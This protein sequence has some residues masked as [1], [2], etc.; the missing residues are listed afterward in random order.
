MY[1]EVVRPFAVA[2]LA[3]LVSCTASR[4]LAQLGREGADV[5]VSIPAVCE[6][7]DKAKEEKSEEAILENTSGNDREP[8]IMNAV[9]DPETGEM[10]ASDVIDASKVVARFRNV[11][12]RNGRVTIEFDVTVPSS[13]VSSK[14]Q[15]R[16]FPAAGVLDETF[17][18]DPILVTGS[19]YRSRQIRGYERYREFISSIISDSSGFVMQK[20]LE[21]FLERNYPRVYAMKNDTSFVSDPEAE[22]IFGVTQKEVLDHYTRHGLVKR[23]RRREEKSGIMLEK[24]TGGLKGRIRLDT[25]ISSGTEVCYRYVQTLDSRPGLRKI[26]VWLSGGVYE[27]GELVY[28]IPGRNAIDFYV[29]SLSSL[30]DSAVRY[31]SV[32]VERSVYGYVNAM[33]DFGK[34]SALLD[35]L[36]GSN[37]TELA[38]MRAGMESMLGNSDYE[39]DSVVVTASCSLEGSYAY[40]SSLAE[41][42]AA[43]VVKILSEGSGGECTKILRQACRPENWERF[44]AVI[45]DDPSVSEESRTLIRSLPYKERPDS[46]EKVLQGLPE[47]RYLKEKVY[48]G[49]R[50][51]RLDFYMHR[52]GMVKDTLCTSEIDS[53]YMRGVAALRNLDYSRAVELLGSYRDYNAALAYLSSGYDAKALEIIASLKHVP[54]RALYLKAIALSRLGM[55]EEASEVFEKCI[56]MDPSM[57]HRGRLDPEIQKFTLKH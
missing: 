28:G 43:A 39:A 20:P 16:L 3:L 49:L 4:Q 1:S 31:R 18:L 17:S 54:A 6:T 9:K 53:A 38:R 8:F 29:S 51:V 24:L 32:I 19:R 41:R 2:V 36:S 56:V 26:P 47:Y 48:P 21:I 30:A 40:N 5:G 15:L 13:M 45:E 42:R 27:D 34:G 33:L 37:V 22:D 7:E 46:S 50:T 11:A 35:T 14:W 25:V 52:K 57:L 44:F 12:E 55:E 10:V 23:N